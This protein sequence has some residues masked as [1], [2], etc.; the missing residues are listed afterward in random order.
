MLLT[1]NKDYFGIMFIFLSNF[2]NQVLN[3]SENSTPMHRMPQEQPLLRAF[4]CLILIRAK[5][6]ETKEGASMRESRDRVLS[7]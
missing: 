3:L 1:A 7:H 5:A 4:I 2:I 6:G